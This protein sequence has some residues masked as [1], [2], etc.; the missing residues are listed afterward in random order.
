M[1]NEKTRKVALSGMLFALAITLSVVES[2]L[3]EPL[4]GLALP[5]LGFSVGVIPGVKIGLSNIVVMFA[6]FFISFPQ[7]LAIAVLKAA[8]VFLT[9]GVLAGFF[10]LCGGLLS[11]TVMWLLYKLPKRPTYFILSV[12]GSLA[13]N[14]GQLIAASI[15]LGSKLALANMPILIISGLGMGLITSTS[16]NLLLPALEKLGY[17]ARE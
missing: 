16:M 3:V 9:R 10:S 6:L 7:A 14:F 12:C 2:A 13:H 1:R 4:L 11:I 15:V 17:K 5:I 8:F